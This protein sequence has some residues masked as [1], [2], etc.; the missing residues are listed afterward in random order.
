MITSSWQTKKLN[1]RHFKVQH[2]NKII[3]SVIRLRYKC[4]QQT[5]LQPSSEP[6]SRKNNNNKTSHKPIDQHENKPNG[7]STLSSKT[8]FSA[9]KPNFSKITNPNLPFVNWAKNKVE[10]QKLHISDNSSFTLLTSTTKTTKTF[11]TLQYVGHSSF[12]PTKTTRS[13]K[14]MN[15]FSRKVPYPQPW[16]RGEREREKESKKKKKRMVRERRERRK[17]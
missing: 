5:N 15:F 14:K 6:P 7:S 2:Q 9:R 1:R 12:S 13:G 8:R 10:N 16:R 3:T 11:L 4:R 17:F